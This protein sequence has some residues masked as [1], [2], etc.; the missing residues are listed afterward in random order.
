MGTGNRISR[1][2]HRICRKRGLHTAK[3]TA[4]TMFIKT[5]IYTRTFGLRLV[6][7]IVAPC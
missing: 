7:P 1:S 2:W 3:Q 6:E 4:T 5:T